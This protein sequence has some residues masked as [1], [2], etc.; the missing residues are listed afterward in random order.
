MNPFRRKHLT[1]YVSE[2]TEFINELKRK[3]PE[4]ES[5]QL[6]GRNLLWNRPQDIDTN[7]EL[8]AGREAQSSYVYY[9]LPDVKK[10]LYDLDVDKR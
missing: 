10:P 4:L 6:Y 8:N 5:K 2:I 3:D 9:S 1:G 7:E